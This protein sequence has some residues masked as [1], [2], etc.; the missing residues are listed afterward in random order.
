MTKNFALTLASGGERVLLVDANLRTPSLHDAFNLEKLM[1][2]TEMLSGNI[3]LKDVIKKT[4]VKNLLVITSGISPSNPFTLFE[5]NSWEYLIAQMKTQAY[6]VLFDSSPINV[7]N[8]ACPLAAKMD[9][10]VMVVEAEKTRWEVAQNAKE[11]IRNGKVNLLGIILNRRKNIPQMTPI[12]S[13]SI[14][15][16]LVYEQKQFLLQDGKLTMRL[17]GQNNP[18]FSIRIENQSIPFVSFSKKVQA[19]RSNRILILFNASK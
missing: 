6:W 3:T 18:S 1:G 19:L 16:F 2:I 12:F 7:Y 4:D 5:S 17:N 15:I 14:M 11:R 10:V 8:D 9:G 13:K